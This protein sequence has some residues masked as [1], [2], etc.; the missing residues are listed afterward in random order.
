M[1][2]KET[3]PDVSRQRTKAAK[4]VETEGEGPCQTRYS[5][6]LVKDKPLYSGKVHERRE[7]N[8]PRNEV[9]ADETDWQ[10]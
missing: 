1:A 4:G 10:R 8:P 2:Q 9:A 3:E 5:K 6:L 7:T